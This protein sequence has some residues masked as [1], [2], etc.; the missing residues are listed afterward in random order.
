M[1]LSSLDDFYA[2]DIISLIKLLE[3]FNELPLNTIP[4]SGSVTSPSFLFFKRRLGLLDCVILCCEGGSLS[5]MAGTSYRSDFNTE[6]R[7]FPESTKLWSFRL[8]LNS[9][10]CSDKGN[11]ED[12]IF[13]ELITNKSHPL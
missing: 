5:V 12:S 4:A 7:K 10:T 11:E 1:K 2:F 9:D 13:T 8:R 3:F 6:L